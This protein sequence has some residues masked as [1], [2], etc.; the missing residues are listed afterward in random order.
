MLYILFFFESPQ[1]LYVC[2]FR[3]FSTDTTEALL[4][5]CCRSGFISLVLVIRDELVKHR[6]DSLCNSI[7]KLA[8][9]EPAH[10]FIEILLSR[11]VEHPALLL[12]LELNELLHLIHVT[13]LGTDVIMIL[14]EKVPLCAHV[15]HLFNRNND[16]FLI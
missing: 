10:I 13:Y 5:L 11:S 1:P 6:G 8:H 15:S 4:V 7:V 3:F 14:E 12:F 2:D 16:V 9:V